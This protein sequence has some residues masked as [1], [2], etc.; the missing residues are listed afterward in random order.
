MSASEKSLQKKTA[1]RWVHKDAGYEATTSTAIIQSLLGVLMK[2]RNFITLSYKGYQSFGTIL[3]KVTNTELVFDKPKDWIEKPARIRVSFKT[4]SKVAHHFY[5]HVISVTRNNL[6]LE[7]PKKI[8]RLQ[9]RT[10]YRIDLPLGSIATFMYNGK[11]CKFNIKDVSLSGM[12][13]YTA[14]DGGFSKS[15][16]E[17]NTI[18]V[19][20]AS[21]E[22]QGFALKIK[23][24][25]IVRS[26]Y[27]KKKK[28][29]FYGIQCFPSFQEEEAIMKYVRKREL[30]LL[31]KESRK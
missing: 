21:P 22:E 6:H 9:R 18:S 2:E 8:Y 26:T 4:S 17:I 10:H 23:K 12:L 16:T 20:P 13:L 19:S 5:T 15:I 30:Q 7:L 29:F 28:I 1:D 3:E 24:G 31:R 25:R 27:N 11:K 14:I